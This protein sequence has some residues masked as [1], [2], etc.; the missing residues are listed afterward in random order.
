MNEY[1]KIFGSILL[2]FVLSH[3]IEQSNTKNYTQLTTSLQNTNLNKQHEIQQVEE[4]LSDVKTKLKIEMSKEV[5]SFVEEELKKAGEHG[6]ISPHIVN[7][8]SNKLKTK[9]FD[10]SDDLNG[11][12]TPSD[13][14]PILYTDIPSHFNLDDSSIQYKSLSL[15]EN[16]VQTPKPRK[17]Y[18]I[19]GQQFS[20]PCNPSEKFGLVDANDSSFDNYAPF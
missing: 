1:Q 13:S 4:V 15:P 20:N 6:Q 10:P 19:D 5:D 14:P 11:S 12:L 2:L 16:P 9:Y 17:S 3:L 7:I 8:I 18:D